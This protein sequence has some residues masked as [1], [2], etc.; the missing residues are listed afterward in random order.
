MIEAEAGGRLL[1]PEAVEIL[2][3]YLI[4]LARVVAPDI[5]EAQALTGVR[6]RDGDSALLA[7]Q[8]I[9][10]LGPKAVIVKAALGLHRYPGDG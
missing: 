3:A 5:F 2:K 1:R 7:A 10:Q 8:S 9:L 4:P 6:V